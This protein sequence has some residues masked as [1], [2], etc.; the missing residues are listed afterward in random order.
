MGIEPAV[1]VWRKSDQAKGGGVKRAKKSVHPVKNAQK[2]AQTNQTQATGSVQKRAIKELGQSKQK[3][4]SPPI[5]K[6]TNPE[7]KFTTERERV[8]VALKL[9]TTQTSKLVGI[10][11]AP[12]AL[13]SLVKQY[14]DK[15]SSPAE[16]TLFLLKNRRQ[17]D[18]FINPDTR[19]NSIDL[20]V[21]F[22]MQW[23][24]NPPEIFS[25][26]FSD[27]CSISASQD[28]YLPIEGLQRLPVADPVDLASRRLGTTYAGP[29]TL[30][31]HENGFSIAF[32]LCKPVLIVQNKKSHVSSK[33]SKINAPK[34]HAGTKAPRNRSPYKRSS[35]PEPRQRVLYTP[36]FSSGS[37]GMNWSGL[38]GRSV[39][40]G[41]PSLG[42]RSR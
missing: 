40:G 6:K 26:D 13:A 36:L 21:A 37:R 10:F 3:Q 38:S 29:F 17:L 22:L 11:E 34:V 8:H 30:F 35:S 42:K 23:S 20:L 19:E 18:G 14:K 32:D 12:R 15:I 31:E 2:P 25:I 16:A 9:S 5:A 28:I 7:S 27:D 1:K 4:L 39:G 33:Q 24:G 41:L